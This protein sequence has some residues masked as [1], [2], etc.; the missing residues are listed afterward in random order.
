MAHMVD[1]MMYSG[2][3]P[4]HGLGEYKDEIEFED[5]RRVLCDVSEHPVQLTERDFTRDVPGYKAL[6]R[7]DTGE[8]L[9]IQ[10]SS[11]G[12]VQYADQL[13]VLCAAAGEGE[14]RLKTVGLL[15]HGRRAF[16]LADIPSAQFDVAGSPIKPYL[17][18]STSH[19]SS[20][21]IR[22]LFTGVYV[23]CNNTETAALQ[24]AGAY[25]NKG[26]FIPN[27]IQ[28]R[29]S[30]RVADRLTMAKQLIAQA[31]VY[32]GAFNEA[33]LI[34]VNKRFSESNIGAHSTLSPN[35]SITTRTVVA[36]VR[37]RW[38]NHGSTTLSSRVGPTSARRRCPSFSRR[39]CSWCAWASLRETPCAP[40]CNHAPL[41]RR[42]TWQ[43]KCIVTT[44]LWSAIRSWSSQ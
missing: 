23:V 24:T 14:L 19:D 18:L 30:K 40:R 15:D 42:R 44:S 28:L 26:S 38:P 36:R 13:D 29:H 35:T 11:Y 4:W 33:A 7:V 27:V 9:C 10:R 37:E 8:A 39:E 12:V 5:A 34:L 43:P 31:R 16:A 41:L 3:V 17:L 2:Q 20:R 32:F 25:N 6:V 22:Y 21:L 1:R